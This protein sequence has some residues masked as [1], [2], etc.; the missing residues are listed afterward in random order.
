MENMEYIPAWKLQDK[1]KLE[2]IYDLY[3]NPR[4]EFLE[5]TSHSKKKK[6]E[7]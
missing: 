1:K 6:K 5:N 3:Y 2:E 4:P 7:N